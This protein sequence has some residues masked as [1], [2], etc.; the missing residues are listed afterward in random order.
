MD[1][2]PVTPPPEHEP[3]RD[4]S[5][6]TPAAESTPSHQELETLRAI[7]DHATTLMYLKDAGGR[8]LFVNRQFETVFHTTQARVLGKTDDELFPKE[9]AQAFRENDLMVFSSGSA[10][11]F[12]E[13]APHEEGLHTY[14]SVKFPIPGPAG[15]IAAVC[16]IS[17]DITDRKRADDEL[18]EVHAETEQLLASISSILVGINA[19]GIITKWNAVAHATFGIAAAAVTLSN[20]P[21]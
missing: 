16:T 3:T 6:S 18:W 19:E 21:A 15:S 7:V 9:I 4:A 2:A 8:Y 10:L 1:R 17:T 11:P 14:L 12:E 13:V 20:L 5:R